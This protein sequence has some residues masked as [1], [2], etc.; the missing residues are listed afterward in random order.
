LL[1]LAGC[2]CPTFETL[3]V[4]DPGGVATDEEIDIVSRA[5]DAFVE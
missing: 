3:N 4:Q 2:G 1:V 5:A